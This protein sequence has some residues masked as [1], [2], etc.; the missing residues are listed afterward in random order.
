MAHS[1]TVASSSALLLLYSSIIIIIIGVDITLAV[2][3]LVFVAM[4]I[5]LQ[6]LQCC[7]PVELVNTETR[8]LQVMVMF[9]SIL[10]LL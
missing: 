9:I 1:L 2:V 5:L 7:L 3:T 4:S 10:L 6:I 8:L